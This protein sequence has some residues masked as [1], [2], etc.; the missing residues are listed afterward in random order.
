MIEFA[1]FKQTGA[2]RFSIPQWPIDLL[3]CRRI[4]ITFDVLQA[5]FERGLFCGFFHGF[6]REAFE[7]RDID[8][9]YPFCCRPLS[10]Y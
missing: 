7:Q 3:I 2:P 8:P 10:G 1:P 4:D 6:V 9:A 5:I